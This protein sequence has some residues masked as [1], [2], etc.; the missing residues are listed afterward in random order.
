MD[1]QI[2]RFIVIILLVGLSFSCKKEVK[3]IKLQEGVWRGEIHMQNQK[4]PFN[5]EILK[6]TKIIRLI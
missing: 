5:F 2:I 3:S 4:L 1:K 6:I